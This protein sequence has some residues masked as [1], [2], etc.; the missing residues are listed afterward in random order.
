MEMVRMSAPAAVAEEVEFF[1]ASRDELRRLHAGQFLVIR[2]RRLLGAF[3]T[4]QAAYLEGVRVCG[5]QPF[6]LAQ[7]G[8]AGDRAWVPVLVELGGEEFVPSPSWRRGE[9]LDDPI[10]ELDIPPP[11]GDSGA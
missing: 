7:V 3:A 11:T 2:G 8:L 9:F 5:T 1:D 4:E 6:L 10:V